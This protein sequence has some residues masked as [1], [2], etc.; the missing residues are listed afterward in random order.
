M[1]FLERKE[2]E[3][4]LGKV[5]EPL[6]SQRVVGGN[7]GLQHSG[8][9]TSPGPILRPHDKGPGEREREDHDQILRQLFQQM[10]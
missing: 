9:Y 2:H 6:H 8:C 5:T 4:E 7:V 1:L 3:I 10:L